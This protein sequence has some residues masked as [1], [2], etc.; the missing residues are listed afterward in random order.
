MSDAEIWVSESRPDDRLDPVA[1]AS[2]LPPEAAWLRTTLKD[3]RISGLLAL[4]RD[5]SEAARRAQR[6]FKAASIVAIVG[7]AVATLAS[8]LLLYGA[9]SDAT[10]SGASAP[11]D[12]TLVGWVRE[13][14]TVIT[15]VQV[16]GLF[17]TTV[18]AGLLGSQNFVARWSGNR[19]Q[20]EAQR[21]EVFNKVLSLAKEATSVPLAGPD[22]GNP[23]RQALEFFRRYQLE[24]IK[25]T[26]A[27]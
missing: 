17:A 6:R 14:R 22:P 19:R 8:G 18:A 1:I 16:A 2:S 5:A 3:S 15:W 10:G 24:G 12:Q 21:R 25:Q 9:G 4:R 11:A 20:A 7:T 13:Q 26:V 23:V 27:R